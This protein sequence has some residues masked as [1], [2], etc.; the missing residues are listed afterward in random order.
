MK[1]SLLPRLRLRVLLNILCPRCNKD[2]Y[3]KF[4]P[5]LFLYWI[6]SEQNVSI[7]HVCTVFVSTELRCVVQLIYYLVQPCSCNTCLCNIRLWI[8]PI[9]LR[10]MPYT[11]IFLESDPIPKFSPF[12]ILSVFICCDVIIISIYVFLCLRVRV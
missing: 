12:W 11:F 7:Y 4:S 5:F 6:D 8:F 2:C 9:L 3:F 10:I 1:N